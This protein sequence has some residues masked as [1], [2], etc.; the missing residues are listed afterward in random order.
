MDAA[1]HFNFTFGLSTMPR[2]FP[3]QDGNGQ[4]KSLPHASIDSTTAPADQGLEEIRERMN[5]ALRFSVRSDHNTPRVTLSTARTRVPPGRRRIVRSAR[6]SS[7]PRFV[8][9]DEISSG[10]D[11]E[12][13][14]SPSPILEPNLLFTALTTNPGDPPSPTQ[15]AL[16]NADVLSEIMSWLPC[17][18]LA[19]LMTT[20][21]F[22]TE[23]AVISLCVCPRPPIRS[24]T[25]LLSFYCFL[26]AGSR[27]PRWPHIRDLHIEA[28]LMSRLIWE[29]GRQ[30][31]LGRGD[32]DL[33]DVLQHI[34]HLCRNLRRLHVNHYFHVED[35]T[36]MSK[37]VSA[38]SSLEE[39]RLHH[40]GKI[41]K[42]HLQRI[43][44]PRLRTLVLDGYYEQIAIPDILDFL[45]PLSSCL[46]D[47]DLRTT[48]QWTSTP[49]SAI[50]PHLRRLTIG[51]PSGGLFGSLK[52][53]PNL[54]HLILKAPASL[55]IYP[56]DEM[57]AAAQ[58]LRESNRQ[59][60][61]AHPDHWP[62]LVSVSSEDPYI[63][64]VLAAPQHIP[65]V[66][67]PQR[68]LANDARFMPV[69]RSALQDAA[70]SC[71]ELRVEVTAH[72]PRSS[73]EET[74][75]ASRF[76]D[77]DLLLAGGIASALRRC[78]ITVEAFPGHYRNSLSLHT[79]HVAMLDAL[80]RLLRTLPLTHLLIKY[81][82]HRESLDVSVEKLRKRLSKRA[83][84]IVTPFVEAC[85]TL[86]WLGIYLEPEALR[87]WEVVRL[88]SGSQQEGSGSSYELQELYPDQSWAV[89]AAEGMQDFV[90]ATRMM[91]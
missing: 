79:R 67:L 61:K 48:H 60:W 25:H 52:M 9:P 56:F 77:F 85:P 45:R 81:S 43:V 4:L 41:T 65:C 11:S 23:A 50:F 58:D 5:H 13:S 49:Q 71:V 88:S 38:M 33:P 40:V 34:L 18:S 73:Q 47:L 24:L 19:V 7:P 6:E 87:T 21:R 83:V 31:Y 55:P 29:E 91:A 15:I 32:G 35:M 76:A 75:A 46:V 74:D 3:D 53:F 68:Y 2:T 69:Y 8:R 30:R 89:L 80:Q 84:E 70:P 78:L 62:P 64:Y 86:R 37:A 57:L 59:H 17:S 14:P 72:F 51:H 90:R 20:C 26:R 39:L 12:D 16:L 63:L 82:N 28:C 36:Y 54:Q 1:S 42:Q 10:S 22:F 27:R 44:R 66:S